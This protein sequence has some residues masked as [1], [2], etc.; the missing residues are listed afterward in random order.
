MPD[1]KTKSPYDFAGFIEGF[2]ASNL[3]FIQRNIALQLSEMQTR[4]TVIKSHIDKSDPQLSIIAP[5]VALINA[6]FF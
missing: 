6:A 1:L 3:A 2:Q 4:L 5:Q